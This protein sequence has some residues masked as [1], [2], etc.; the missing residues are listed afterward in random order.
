MNI[1]WIII[2]LLLPAGLIW[3]CGKYKFLNKIGIVLLC[4]AVGMIL[5]NTGI[6]PQSLTAVSVPGGDSPLSLLQ[7]V[8]VCLALPMILFSLDLKRWLRVA[9]KGLLCMLLACAAIIIVAFLIHITIGQENSAS[10]QYAAASVAVY[11]GG[12]INLGSIRAV[13][14]MSAD[15]YIVFNTYDAVIGVLYLLFLST[16]GRS[17]FRKIFRLPAFESAAAGE[18]SNS[19]VIDES[20]SAYRV[21]LRRETLPGL[22][23]ALFASAVIF[24]VSYVLNILVSKLDPS[25]GMTVM[26]LSITTLG[27]AGSFST[28]LRSIAHS[29]QFGMYIIYIFCISVAAGADFSALLNFNFTIF[30]YVA[31]ALAG[32]MLLHAILCKLFNIDSDTMII[33]S[34]SAICSPPFV[35][36][37]AASI[38]NRD[39]MITGLATGVIGYAI[40][41]YLGAAVNWLFRLI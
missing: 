1:L 36:S 16:V 19:E 14:G 27:I 40:G 7:S 29:F 28:R 35:P 32:S 13:I 15:D 24:G 37:V 2:F 8:T 30:A 12:T 21:L 25:L 9:R 5:G 3:L 10:P 11:T 34:V 20:P 38:H 26:M 23:L 39:I 18:I 33:T 22:L 17:F 4:Y 31:V 41:N 6:L